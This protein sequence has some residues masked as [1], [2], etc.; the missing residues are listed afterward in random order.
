MSNLRQACNGKNT[1]RQYHLI[2]LYCNWPSGPWNKAT[3]I[4]N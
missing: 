4:S 2:Q 1:C 3:K